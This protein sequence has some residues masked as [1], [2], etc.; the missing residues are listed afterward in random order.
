MWDRKTLKERAKAAFKL[1]YW[2]SVAVAFVMGLFVSG[3]ATSGGYN[4]SDTTAEVT[5]EYSST[6]TPE[7]TAALVAIVIGAVSFLGFIA[8]VIRALVANPIE[9]GGRRFF[10]KNAVDQETPFATLA[11][12]FQNYGHVIV[13][14]LVRDVFI[15]LWS[16]LF[17]IPGIMKSYSYRM[18]PY[19]VKDNPELSPTETLALSAQMMKGNRWQAF[20]MDLSFIGWM[21]LG[22]VTLNL[23]NIFWTAPY[24]NATDA[25]LYLELKNQA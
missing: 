23:G 8:M 9:V 1:N 15:V 11:E 20:V 24:M 5:T 17:V 14:L 10:R 6:L 18:V 25:E 22:V 4:V 21:L 12:G 19:I 13:T 16:L 2:P 7:Q 3:V